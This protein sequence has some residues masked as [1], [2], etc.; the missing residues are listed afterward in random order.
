MKLFKKII[1]SGEL[2]LL[3][4]MHIGDSKENVEIGGVDSPIIRRKDNNQ[5][6]I[7]GSSLKGKLRSL[8]EVAMGENADT[9]FTD[10]KSE[11]GK[12]LAYLFGSKD[13]PA[14]ILV[15][16]APLTIES[17]D[18]L[19][20]SEFT[21]MPYTEVKFEN[22]INRLTGTADHPR[23]IERVPA[24]AVFK[25]EF[26]VN[27]ME[28]SKDNTAKFLALL[29]SGLALLQNDYLGGSGTRGYGQVEWRQTGEIVKTASEYL[30][31]T[32]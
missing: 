7:P 15:R 6:Y 28:D 32:A 26:V 12:L 2:K 27:V 22:V 11:N 5:P 31:Q 21:D 16:D 24:G 9:S 29:N 30:N 19:Y 3:S 4:G 25:I 14:R 20:N 18:K 13:N 8:L 17:A 10:Y 23:Q 1:I